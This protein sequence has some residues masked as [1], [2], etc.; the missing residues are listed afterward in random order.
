MKNNLALLVAILCLVPLTAWG[1]GSYRLVDLSHTYDD[2]TLF[3]PT[4][5]TRFKKEELAFGETDGG[6]FYSAY[7]ICTPEHGGTHLD[8]PIHFA[9][10]GKTTDQIELERLIAPGVVI[11][12][13][14]QSARDRNYRLSLADVEDW[15]K[16]NG[17]I[18][19]GSIVL[20]RSGWSQHWPDAKA[21]LG[22]DTPGD[23]SKLS[24]PGYGAEATRFL[25]EQR[26][27]SL[28]GVDSA[29]IDH[30]PSKDFMAHRIAAKANVGALENLT[31]LEQLPEQG[32]T[33]IAL[34]V[35]VGGGS[36]GP[37]RVVAMIPQERK[38]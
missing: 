30:G 35:K 32:F 37:V 17:Q 26:G 24:F 5:P 21:Y 11:D 28:L 19:P 2:S 12:V 4:S 3:W 33:I 7:S 10:G 8:A 36:G 38:Q 15:E 18:E 29:S 1:D 20:M 31:G 13:S 6:Y 16:R 9:A 27:V 34:P 14:A 23:A 25:V 22:D